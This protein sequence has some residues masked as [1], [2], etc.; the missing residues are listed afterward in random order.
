AECQPDSYCDGAECRS[1]VDRDAPCSSGDACRPDLV[2]T[3]PAAGDEG[4]CRL[5]SEVGDACSDSEPCVGGYFCTAGECRS[6]VETGEECSQHHHCSNDELCIDRDAGGPD[7]STCGES[8]AEGA[9]C[10][11]SLDCQD[12]LFCDTSDGQLG[13][14]TPRL[15]VGQECTVGDSCVATAF[16]NQEV[17]E[18]QDVGQPGDSC[19]V[20]DMPWQDTACAEGLECMSN[21]ECHPALG[22]LGA[23]CRTT[24]EG[25]CNP[26]LFCSRETFVCEPAGAE[27]DF[28]NPF[29]STS[30]EGDLACLCSGD[31]CEYGADANVHDTLHTCQ[32]RRSIGDRCFNAY[33]CPLDA[34]CQDDAG[35]LTCVASSLCLPEPD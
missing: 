8:G 6:K 13:L 31:E 21:G 26:G 1:R 18:C 17:G 2:C 3:W 9:A 14:C 4:V 7:P 22:E 33:E 10:N 34:Y 27:G 29:W 19:L 24:N 20:F 12:A 32:P 30:C 11:G 25:S 23:A 35:E 28:C 16:C 5:P 15:P